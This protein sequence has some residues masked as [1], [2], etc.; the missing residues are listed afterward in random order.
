MNTKLLIYF[1]CSILLLS[2]CELGTDRV[3]M[4]MYEAMNA[5]SN[6][7]ENSIEER[8]RAIADAVKSKPDYKGLLPAAEKID[9]LTSDF[10]DF[11][12]RT[13]QYLDERNHKVINDDEI[14]G[15]IIA[16]RHKIIDVLK[17]LSSN[18]VLWIKDEEIQELIEL[19]FFP[20]DILP[21]INGKPF[22]DY[23]FKNQSIACNK[24]IL[25]KQ[26]N[27]ALMLAKVAVNYLAGK[28]GHTALIFDKAVVVSAPKAPF[29]VKG[30]T[31]ETQIFL[32]FPSRSRQFPVTIKVND[33]ELPTKDGIATYTTTPTTYGEHIYN[34]KIT[35]TNPHN[36][37]YETYR[38][39][40]SFEVGERCY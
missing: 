25:A 32:S 36:D 4:E 21:L 8:I 18:K 40:F 35:L 9:D 23:S 1:V 33:I 15:K 22:D 26:K 17:A 2:S 14:K 16:H 39:P 27:D 7:I 31:F 11:T 19:H 30:Q 3:Y 29:I 12:E 38:R 28:I 24:A 6:V 10:T 5:N 37:K 13:N 20:D 34:V